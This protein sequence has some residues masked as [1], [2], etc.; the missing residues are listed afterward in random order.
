MDPAGI[1]HRPNPKVSSIITILVVIVIIVLFLFKYVY[2]YSNW[3]SQKCLNG[4]WFLAPLFGKD[5]KKA[6]NDCINESGVDVLGDELT[7]LNMRL[8][9]NDNKL[10]SQDEEIEN[11]RNGNT[12]INK[13]SRGGL[14]N[15]VTSSKENN[16]RV[17]GALSNLT[18]SLLVSSKINQDTMN[19]SKT[20]N[21]SSFANMLKK[22]RDVSKEVN[23][24]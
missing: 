10:M 8:E 4:N 2:I 6:L 1:Y 15:V 14:Y 23:K 19:M 24:K 22:Y 12:D 18:K 21:S 9:E 11:I 13:V 7:N 5:S 17:K 16:E 20:L 3:S